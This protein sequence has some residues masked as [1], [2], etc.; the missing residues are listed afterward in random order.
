LNFEL[1]PHTPF[2]TDSQEFLRFYGKFH[3]KLVEDFFCITV[4]DKGHGIFR[5]YAPLIAVKNLVFAYF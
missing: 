3:R 4:Y 1:S 5:G 2:Q